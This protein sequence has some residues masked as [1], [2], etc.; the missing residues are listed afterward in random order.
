MNQNQNIDINQG[1]IIS[2]ENNQGYNTLNEP[3]RLTIKRD[4]NNVIDKIKVVLFPMKTKNTK[5]L[6]DWD[7]WG[8]L[9]LCL[10]LGF[11]LSLQKKTENSGIIF[12]MIFFI[13]WVGGLIVSLNSQFQGINL[14]IFQCICILGY[15]M[16][17]VVLASTINLILGFLPGFI[18]ILISLL[19][20]CYSTFGKLK[21]K[22]TLIYK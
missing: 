13:V 22:I 6:Q 9:I 20:C 12:I 14:S 11:V 5:L 3:K 21:Y 2:E 15:C 19:G 1:E 8:P 4:L 7:F 10:T 17:A 18:R 16:F